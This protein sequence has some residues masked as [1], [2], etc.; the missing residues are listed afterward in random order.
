MQQFHT[1][2]HA[3]E[4]VLHSVEHAVQTQLAWLQPLADVWGSCL[5]RLRSIHEE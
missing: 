4:T 1:S 5:A 3:Y 2:N